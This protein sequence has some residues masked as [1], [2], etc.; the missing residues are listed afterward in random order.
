[1]I[2][3]VWRIELGVGVG[4][5]RLGA[6]IAEALH[7]LKTRLPVHPFEISYNAV[8]PY[9]RDV[10]VDSAEDGFRTL[11]SI[12]F[13]NVNRVALK[14]GRVVIFGGDIAATFMSVYNLFGP[15]F[16]GHYDAAEQ[17]MRIMMK[18]CYILGYQGGCVKFPI[19]AEYRNL[20][21]NGT[22]LPLEFPN[23]A[24]PAATG[25]TVFMGGD[26]WSPGLPAPTKK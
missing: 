19:P 9:K 23:G 24:T 2:R 8:D 11:K 21:E 16:P 17:S 22:D 15:T 7:A 26:Y 25:L 5:F 4:P 20:Y 12:E 10:V 3:E 18:Q 13:Y 14:F 1:M 6:S